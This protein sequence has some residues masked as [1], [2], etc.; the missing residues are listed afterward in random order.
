LYNFS[1]EDSKKNFLPNGDPQIR[2]NVKEI[3]SGPGPYKPTLDAAKADVKQLVSGA[4]QT[5]VARKKNP[6]VDQVCDGACVGPA[7]GG[8]VV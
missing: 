4:L 1:N 5:M 6:G 7:C 3:M 8:L 2:Q